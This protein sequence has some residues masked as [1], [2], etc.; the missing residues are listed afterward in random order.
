MSPTVVEFCAGAG[1]MAL[2]LERAGFVPLMLVEEQ[3]DPCATLLLNRPLWRV[4]KAD[5][6]TL[7]RTLAQGTDLLAAGIPCPPF[8]RAGLQLGQEDVRDLF[9]TLLAF[10]EASRPRA[11]LIENVPGL[12]EPRFKDYRAWIETFLR[13]LR[14]EVTWGVLNAMDFGVPQ[15]RQRAFLVALEPGTSPLRWT[16]PQYLEPVTVGEAL[17][18]FMA[19]QG[20]PGAR[21]WAMAA[22]KPAPTLVGG[23][24]LHGGADLGPTRT[25]EAWRRLGV[26][27]TSLANAPP[28]YDDPPSLHPR[29]TL[30]MAARLQGFP[31]DWFFAGGKT[32]TYRQIGNACP[33]PLAEAM[34]RAVRE[35]LLL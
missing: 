11:L 3:V 27:A 2:G 6:R 8:S 24:C 4:R 25:R 13:G 7:P 16:Q 19:A 17:L 23:S 34:G 26:S 15:R 10:T 35:A 28:A 18:P 21:A 20:W 14:Y 12:L 22:G 31:N 9:P 5:I 33:P 1:G 30:A 29:L 32:A